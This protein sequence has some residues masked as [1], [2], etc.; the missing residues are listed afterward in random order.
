MVKSPLVF[1]LAAVKV[2]IPL[3]VFVTLTAPLNV[4]S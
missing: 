4:P 1:W 2:K 3:P